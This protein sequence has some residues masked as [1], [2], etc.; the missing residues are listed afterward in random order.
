[1]SSH[2]A[3]LTAPSLYNYGISNL[4][5]SAVLQQHNTDLSQ[6]INQ[7]LGGLSTGTIL[8]G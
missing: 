1:M 7:F 8:L 5:V 4:R 2:T 3:N 6:S